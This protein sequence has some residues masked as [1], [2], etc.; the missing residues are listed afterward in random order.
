MYMH[1][2]HALL[3][4]SSQSLLLSLIH[5]RALSLSP[6]NA[7]ILFYTGNEG[8]IFNFYNNTGAM[9]ELGEKVNTCTK[10]VVGCVSCDGQYHTQAHTH[11]HA[12][13]HSLCMLVLYSICVS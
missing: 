9:W 13:T 10:R 3:S 6:Q 2:T 11:T 12:R 1:S 5:F 7:P 8:D 4:L